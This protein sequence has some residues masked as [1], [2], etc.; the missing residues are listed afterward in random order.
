MG[1]YGSYMTIGD[2]IQLLAVFAAVGASIIALVIATKDRRTQLA[3]AEAD[4]EQSR[5][6]IELEYAIRLSA[7]RNMGGSTDDGER[8]RLGSEALALAGVVGERWVPRQYDRA[9]DFKSPEQLRAMLGDPDETTPRWVKDKI[10][11]GLA[12]Q[13]IVAA[14]RAGPVSG[15]Q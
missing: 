15:D 8:K 10:E 13:A 4:R 9:M 6:A 3:I 11:A 1:P 14:L 7:N 5:L 12:V 2:V